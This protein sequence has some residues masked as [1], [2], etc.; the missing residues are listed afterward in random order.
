MVKVCNKCQEE[1]PLSDFHKNKATKDGH[2]YFCKECS[3]QR[4]LD[5]YHD[6]VNKEPHHNADRSKRQACKKYGITTDQYDEMLAKQNNRCAICETH[7]SELKNKTN[8]CIDHNH[9]T[10][11]VRGLLC[12]P[13]NAGMGMLGDNIEGLQRAINYLRDNDE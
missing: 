7:I 12:G 10:M 13:C 8:F 11:A 1:K 3:N 4:C 9:E 5:D 6:K 2:Q